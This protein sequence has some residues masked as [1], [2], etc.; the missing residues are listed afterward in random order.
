MTGLHQGAVPSGQPPTGVTA[1]AYLH[2]TAARSP[3][4][5]EGVWR[6]H[7][8]E[9]AIEV[10][11]RELTPADERVLRYYAGRTRPKDWSEPGAGPV[12]YVCQLSAAEALN[13]DRKSVYN[14]EC[15]LE[16]L[17]LAAKLTLPNGH[18]RGPRGSRHV[19]EPLGIA[20]YPAILAYDALAACAEAACAAREA[21]ERDRRGLMAVRAL[22]A[23]ALRTCHPGDPNIVRGATQTPF[24]NCRSRLDRRADRGVPGPSRRSPDVS[25]RPGERCG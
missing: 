19:S 22:L 10:H 23:R 17:G 15:K 1:A 3:G 6:D 9:L 20:F 7:L 25:E 18:R 16:A 14:A 8:I 13:L 2:D 21:F 12:C 4:L 11:R 24:A 5:P